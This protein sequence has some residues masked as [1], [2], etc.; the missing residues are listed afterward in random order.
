M[1]RLSQRHAPPHFPTP[2]RPIHPSAPSQLRVGNKASSPA[3]LRALLSPSRLP[4][5]DVVA[6]SAAVAQVLYSFFVMPDT[7]P[8]SYVHFLARQV[9][10]VRR[11]ECEP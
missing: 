5:S 3:W 10:G 9:M 8:H 6:F 2:S 7:L 4:H 1:P 11:W